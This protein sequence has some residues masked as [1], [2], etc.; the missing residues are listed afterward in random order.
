MQEETLRKLLQ[1]FRSE[2]L[3][4]EKFI[5]KL[6]TLPFEDYDF[7]KLD[8]HRALRKGFPEVIYGE[9]KSIK[10]LFGNSD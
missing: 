1:Q 3:S 10:D 5:Q 9:G 7:V 4:E 2:K 8:H 6:K